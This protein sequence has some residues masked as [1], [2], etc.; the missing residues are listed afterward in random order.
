MP[1]WLIILFLLMYAVFEFMAAFSFNNKI[2]MIKQKKYVKAATLGAFSTVIFTFLTSFASF[3][4]LIGGGS[5]DSSMWWFIIAAAFMMALGN[6][7]AMI[8]LRPFEKF[9]KNRELENKSLGDK[10]NK[11]ERITE[12]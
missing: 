7:L 8:A 11:N 4:A 10:K 3:I 6:I 2:R 9:I 5:S 1:I 12:W